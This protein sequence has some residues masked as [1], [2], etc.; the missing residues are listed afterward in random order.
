MTSQHP[1]PADFA[2]G[3]DFGGTKIE[4]AALSPQGDFLLR[5]RAPN[6]GRYEGAIALIR[7]LVTGAEAEL[8]GRG[9]VG[10]GLPGSPSPRTGLMR[11]ANSTF[12]NGRPFQKDLAAALGRA[13]RIANDANCFALSEAVDGAGAGAAVVFGVILGTGCGGGLVVHAELIE[14]ASGIGAELGHNPLPWPRAEE[15]PGPKCWCGQQNCLESWV[16]GTGLARAFQAETGRALRSEEI[17]AA[18]RNGDGE[19]AAAFDRYVDRLARVLA[20]VANLVDPDVFVLG[21]GMSNVQEIYPRL[22]EKIMAY[23]F[24]DDW[25]GKVLPAKFGDSSGV[26][27]AARLL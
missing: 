18:M 8:G 16:S 7:D 3:I 22:P 9:T 10:I 24:G 23:I 17:I 15:L 1:A 5:R 13:V 19:A 25:E 14:G 4:I 12:L 6:P 11:N 21:G 26:R 20:H 27:G 2:L